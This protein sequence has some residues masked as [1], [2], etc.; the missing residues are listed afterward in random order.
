MIDHVAANLLIY[1][2]IAGMI[3]VVAVWYFIV[4]PMERKDYERKLELVQQKIEKHRNQMSTE[5]NNLR[6]SNPDDRAEQ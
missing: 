6:L 5:S 2:I 1:A 4:A 3:F